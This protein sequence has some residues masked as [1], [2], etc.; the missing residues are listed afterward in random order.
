MSLY[1]HIFILPFN[2]WH[3]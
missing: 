1:H 2:S 3:Q